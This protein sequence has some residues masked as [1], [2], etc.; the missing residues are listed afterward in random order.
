MLA[1]AMVRPE[2]V[3]RKLAQLHGYLDELGVH[4][5]VSLDGYLR[6]GGPRREVERLLQLIVEAAVDVNVHVVT[7]LE[8]K[9]PS[10]YRSSFMAAAGHGLI[11]AE[12]AE[13]L[14]PA[15]DWR[16]ILVHEYGDVRDDL[17]HAS[18]APAL[19]D[20]RAFAVSVERWLSDN[21]R[22]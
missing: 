10:D 17:V 6:R 20:F 7:E 19:E 14:A 16:N 15:A 1:V 12:L 3:R 2:V 22:T 13:R 18:I 8:G 4:A 11:A 5:D 21:Y 9:P